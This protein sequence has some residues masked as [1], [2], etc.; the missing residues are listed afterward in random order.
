[1]LICYE[2]GQ[3]RRSWRG[4]YWGTL[5]AIDTSQLRWLHGLTRLYLPPVR[6]ENPNQLNFLTFTPTMVTLER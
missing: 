4:S 2:C 6:P 1:M 5:G 3:R